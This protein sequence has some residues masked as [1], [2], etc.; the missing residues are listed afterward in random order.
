MKNYHC[1]WIRLASHPRPVTADHGVSEKSFIVAT[2]ISLV[3]W[4][5]HRQ[6]QKQ[7]EAMLAS[8]SQV[9]LCEEHVAI[10]GISMVGVGIVNE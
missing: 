4:S 10:H 5:M 8:L 6:Q 7:K 1:Q 2:N 3:I 9:A